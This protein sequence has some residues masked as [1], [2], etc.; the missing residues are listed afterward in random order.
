MNV[1]NM[2][3]IKNNVMDSRGQLAACCIKGQVID[4]TKT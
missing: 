3:V 4:S 1:W 2:T